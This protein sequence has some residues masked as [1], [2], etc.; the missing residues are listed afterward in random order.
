M[1][2]EQILNTAVK[3]VMILLAVYVVLTM[4]ECLFPNVKRRYTRRSYADRG[5]CQTGKRLTENSVSAVLA[6][7]K[8]GYGSR[9]D[10]RIT[11]DRV[12]VAFADPDLQRACG[13]RRRISELTLKELSGI[14]VFGNARVATLEEILSAVSSLQE[15][16]PLLLTLHPDCQGKKAICAFCSDVTSVFYPHRRICMVESADTDV[17]HYCMVNYSNIVRGLRMESR[18]ESALP[19][20]EFLAVSRMLRNMKTRP[21]FFDTTAELYSLFYWV[22]VTMGAFLIMREIRGEEERAQDRNKYRADAFVFT[23][24]EPKSTF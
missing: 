17:I 13:D 5:L 23:E 4:G 15:P 18:D 14:P 22:P 2:M 11:S 3:A 7:A 1:S 9:I 21:Q 8:K 6:A 20:K 24:G 16:V 10:V 12:P 19:E